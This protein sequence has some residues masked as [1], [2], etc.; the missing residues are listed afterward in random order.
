[1]GREVSFV[2]KFR[3]RAPI[4][5]GH[6]RH[7]KLFIF[8]RFD[9][10]GTVKAAPETAVF[11]F[12]LVRRGHFKVFERDDARFA[13][14]VEQGFVVGAVIDEEGFVMRAVAKVVPQQRQHAVFRLDLRAEDAVELGKAEKA[15]Q[16]F[17]FSVE[18]A[19]SFEQRQVGFIAQ[20]RQK[21]RSLTVKRRDEAVD[22]QFLIRHAR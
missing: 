21:R 19:H 8:A 10:D 1:M 12:R 5:L 9:G 17:R 22:R 7:A 11:C 16:L 3:H 14:A 20:T 6:V 18:V 15:A 4:A 2:L 13:A